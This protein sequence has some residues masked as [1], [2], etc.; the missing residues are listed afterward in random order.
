VEAICFL[1]TAF[2]QARRTLHAL[3]PCKSGEDPGRGRP[4]DQVIWTNETTDTAVAAS[5]H[6]NT[7]RNIFP[8][9]ST[10]GPHTDR[11]IA[12]A[13]FFQTS[14]RRFLITASSVPR[15]RDL[16]VLS[17]LRECVEVV[18]VPTAILLVVSLPDR[19]GRVSLI[20]GVETK[21]T[22]KWYVQP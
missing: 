22:K 8:S 7:Y 16:S 14:P 4:A 5:P 1:A 17:V 9:I 2:D 19:G 12:A 6:V 10:I 13:E 15:R 3:H 18:P 20:E 11:D 21:K